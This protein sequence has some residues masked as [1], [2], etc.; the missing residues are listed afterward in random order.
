MKDKA[1]RILLIEDSSGDALLLTEMLAEFA[2]RYDVTRASRL[3]AAFE[4]MEGEG[5]DLVMMDLNL[6]DSSGIQ[7]LSLVREKLPLPVIVLTGLFDSELAARAIAEGAGYFLVKGHV[8]ADE[9]DRI[10]RQC[11]GGNH[12]P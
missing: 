3:S 2:G 8:E 5:F 7:S 9:L 10:I 12:S 11:L 1:I 4:L 6:P